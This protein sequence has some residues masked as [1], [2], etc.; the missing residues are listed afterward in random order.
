MRYRALVLL[1]LLCALLGLPALAERRNERP[2]RPEVWDLELG[3]EVARLPD[4]FIDYACGDNGGPPSLPLGGFGDYR[5]CRPEPSGLR[6]VYFRYDD[7]LEYWAK[8]NDLSQQL[9]QYSGTK[10]YGFPVV[11]SALIDEAGALRG[12]RLVSDPRGD[13]LR[14]DEAYLLRNFLT[15]RFGRDGWTCDELAA[16]P[17]ETPVDGIFVKQHCRKQIDERT[18]ATLTTRHLR[19][20]GQSH[21]DPHTGRETTGQFE[22]SVRFELVK[23]K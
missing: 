5:R 11:V 1:L 17:G 8:A 10:T 19:K 20:A 7:E 4:A 21:F 22:S 18:A 2:A 14:R 12:I 3:V 16:A 9:E 15:A 13:S 6:E 23:E